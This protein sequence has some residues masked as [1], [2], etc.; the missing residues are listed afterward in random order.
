MGG[1]LSNA[2]HAFDPT[3]AMFSPIQ[4]IEF[5]IQQFEL[6]EQQSLVAQLNTRVQELQANET[7]IM[8]GGA[9][10]R[11]ASAQADTIIRWSS[12]LSKIG[13]G[14]VPLGLTLIAAA[15][16]TSDTGWITAVPVAIIAFVTMF[17]LL[18]MLIFN[19][20]ALYARFAMDFTGWILSA[21]GGIIV[22]I[23]VYAIYPKYPPPE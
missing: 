13:V 4:Q 12:R 21:A 9:V 2:F 3:R 22:G 8:K 15:F 1:I 23:I 10:S 11:S 16:A 6:A 20:K 14:V 5:G 18:Q 19:V 17:F 7:V